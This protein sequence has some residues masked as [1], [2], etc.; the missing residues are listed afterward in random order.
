MTC[1]QRAKNTPS[2]IAIYAV[3]EVGSLHAASTSKHVVYIFW[4]SYAGINHAGP[5][6]EVH[7]PDV[8]PKIMMYIVVP[9]SDVHQNASPGCL[10]TEPCG[11]T[12]IQTRHELYHNMRMV[13]IC[14]HDELKYSFGVHRDVVPILAVVVTTIVYSKHCRDGTCVCT[15]VLVQNS[16]T[17]LE[18][19][20]VLDGRGSRCANGVPEFV[21][22]D[23]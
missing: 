2:C 12:S 11:C 4:F 5:S 6:A 15:D 13:Y 9:H 14:C 10:T 23:V 20:P 16:P 7:H 1:L 18:A 17:C 3:F 8:A 19:A 22:T 21:A